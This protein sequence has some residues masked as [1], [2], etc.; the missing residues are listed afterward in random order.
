MRVT[1]PKH[2][3]NETETINLNGELYNGSYELINHPEMSIVVKDESGKEYPYQFD[4]RGNAYALDINNYSVGNYSFVAKAVLNG[5]ALS[6]SGRFT[7]IPLQVEAFN[8][9]ANHQLLF[10]I[11]EKTGARLINQEQL[12]ELANE[13]NNN[14]ELKA[15]LIENFK[16][17]SLINLKWLFAIIVGFLSIEWFVRKYQGGY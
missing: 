11:S 1:I 10:Q 8:S 4:K 15:T 12:P 16:T 13:L 5:K 2:V 9:K 14:T 17:S 6:Y 3:F 7:I